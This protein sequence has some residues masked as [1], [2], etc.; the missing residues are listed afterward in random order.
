MLVSKSKDDNKHVGM[1]TIL[2][3]NDYGG[4]LENDDL[5]LI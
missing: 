1:L 2:L 4:I 3:V 5:E